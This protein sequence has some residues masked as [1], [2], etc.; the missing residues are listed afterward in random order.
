MHE[1]EEQNVLGQHP[2]IEF[3]TLVQTPVA[4]PLCSI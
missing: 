4:A 1:Q 2:D 3:T